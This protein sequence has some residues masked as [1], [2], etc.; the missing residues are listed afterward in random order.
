MG[1]VPRAYESWRRDH[2]LASAMRNSVVWYFQRIAEKLGM[3]RERDYLKRFDYGNADP[4]SGLTTFWLGQS[5]M[6]SPDE[7][8][9]FLRRL[10]AGRPVSIRSLRRGRPTRSSARR[11]AA[12]PIETGGMCGGWWA[13]CA[14]DRARGCSSARPPAETIWRRSRQSTS[15][16]TRFATKASSADARHARGGD[17]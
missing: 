2:T 13:T 16:R 17:A 5:L 6:I 8:L 7:Q 11:P 3:A 14:A 1:R 10:Y 9:R 4:S 12:P 15:P